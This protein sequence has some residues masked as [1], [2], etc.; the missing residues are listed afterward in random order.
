MRK[1]V[2]LGALTV[3]GLAAAAAAA[4]TVDD[5]KARGK[6][7]CGVATGVPGFAAPDANGEWMGFDVSVCRAVAASRVPLVSAVGHER[8]VTLCDEVADLRVS[9]PTAA[10]R[11]VV[12]DHVALVAQ[13]DFRGVDPEVHRAGA[14]PDDEAAHLGVRSDD[15]RYAAVQASEAGGA[16]LVVHQVAAR[17]ERNARP[18]SIEVRAAH[19]LSGRRILQANPLGAVIGAESDVLPEG[20]KVAFNGSGIDDANM[21]AVLSKQGKLLC[22]QAECRQQQKREQVDS[23]HGTSF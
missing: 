10:A 19:R 17:H 20:Q 11:A 2:F 1:S 13:A 12:P 22:L 18:I 21:V 23:S 9:T 15:A 4:G 5:V 16:G 7:N 8:D 3:A 6:L 14:E